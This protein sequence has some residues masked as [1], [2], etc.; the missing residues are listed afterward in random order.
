ML[1]YSETGKCMFAIPCVILV[2]DDRVWKL[3]SQPAATMVLR[4]E[5]LKPQ[6]GNQLP[7]YRHFNLS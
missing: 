5:Q 4:D 7:K 3:H 6:L 2:K 1:L